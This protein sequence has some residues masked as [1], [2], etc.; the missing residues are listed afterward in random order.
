MDKIVLNNSLNHHN[1][2]PKEMELAKH[3]ITLRSFNVL[4][5]NLMQIGLVVHD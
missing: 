4:S 5:G 2:K 3:F 1:L